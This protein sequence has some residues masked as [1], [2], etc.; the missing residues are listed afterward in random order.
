M[1]NTF[2]DFIARHVNTRAAVSHVS[3]VCH[4]GRAIDISDNAAARDW[5]KDI[6]KNACQAQGR[7]ASD[8][9]IA[10][11]RTCSRRRST[12]SRQ[13]HTRWWELPVRLFGMRAYRCRDCYRRF[14]GGA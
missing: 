6:D 3:H 13:A 5:P 14:F 11:V 12:D 1:G 8:L 2:K 4:T 7:G 10:R 9:R